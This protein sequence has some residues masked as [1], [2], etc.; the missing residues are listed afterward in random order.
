M[1]GTIGVDNLPIPIR[2]AIKTLRRERGYGFIK[3]EDG[4][5]YFFHHSCVLGR[6]DEL[7]ED[8]PVMFEIESNSPHPEKGPRAHNVER[9]EVAEAVSASDPPDA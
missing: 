4:K 6:Y 2:G 1:T 3:G 5:D 9:V 7:S 8:D